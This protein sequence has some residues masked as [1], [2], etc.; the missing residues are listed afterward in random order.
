MVIIDYYKSL[1]KKEKSIFREEV[2][3]ETQMSY[4]S[5]F[6]KIRN[7]SFK[8]AEKMMITAIIDRRTNAGKN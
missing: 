7:N 2:L 3:T 8:P 5:F 4:P 6:Y 1:D